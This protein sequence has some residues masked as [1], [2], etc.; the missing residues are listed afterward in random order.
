MLFNLSCE[1]KCLLSPAPGY[2]LHIPESLCIF[3]ICSFFGFVFFN[4]IE[5][6][7][8]P[9]HFWY[10]C[11][12]DLRLKS[13]PWKIITGSC[14]RD[15]LPIILNSILASI[16]FES[17][18]LWFEIANQANMLRKRRETRRKVFIHN[19]SRCKILFH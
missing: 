16:S 3:K 5:F 12:T 17:L 2:S 4:T 14:R 9:D 18:C 6:G 11:C 7:L 15:I 13:K 1:R 10:C 8:I 19:T